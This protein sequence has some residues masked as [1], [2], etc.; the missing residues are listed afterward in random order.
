ME[1]IERQQTV[2]KRRF[3]VEEFHKMGEVGIF[4][5]DERV[6]LIDG[7]VVKMSPPGWRHAWCVRQLNR[8]LVRFAEERRSQRGDLYEVSVQDPLVTGEHGQPQP[9]LALIREPPPGRLPNA[10][11]VLIVVEVSDSSL[12][13]DTNIKL[14]RYAAASVPEVWILDL[15]ANS[16]EVHSDPTPD[17][18]RKTLRLKHGEKVESSTI[19]GLDFDASEVLPPKDPEA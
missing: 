12:A 9:D 6:E 5:E 8:I 17:G 13:Y 15:Q 19:P 2:E 16:I 4:G 18:Y 11:D 14:P 10:G 1:T 3:T 7:E